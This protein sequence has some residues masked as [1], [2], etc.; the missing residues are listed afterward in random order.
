MSNKRSKKPLILNKI[1]LNYTKNR[2]IKEIQ[3]ENAN[4]DLQKG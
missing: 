4:V 2:R 1:M 3:R